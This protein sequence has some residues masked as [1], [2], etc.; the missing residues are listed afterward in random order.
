MR[1]MGAT[2]AHF[3]AEN[4]LHT[5][6]LTSVVSVYDNI[7]PAH[8]VLAELTEW[9]ENNNKEVFEKIKSLQKDM[10]WNPKI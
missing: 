6:N 10:S 9:A 4:V 2:D 5:Q 1:K 8:M 7:K 3:T